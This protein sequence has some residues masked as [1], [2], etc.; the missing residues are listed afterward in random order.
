M[1]L[2]IGTRLGPNEVQASIGAGGMGEVYRA[3]DINL[4]REAGNFV[5]TEAN[6]TTDDTR[7]LVADVS[8]M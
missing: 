5:R 1:T 4:G 6:A 8:S 7:Y 3:V 2:A